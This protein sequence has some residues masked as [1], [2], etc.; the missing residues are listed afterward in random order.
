MTASQRTLPPV[1]NQTESERLD[2]DFLKAA[3]WLESKSAELKAAAHACDMQRTQ[4][5]N[6]DDL[7]LSHLRKADVADLLSGAIRASL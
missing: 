1:Q 3:V 6:Y 5:N 4:Y 2:M 7:K